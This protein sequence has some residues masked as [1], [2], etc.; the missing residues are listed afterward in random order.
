M[1]RYTVEV[2]ALYI[3]EADTPE[4]AK[5]M[6]ADGAEYPVIPYSEET[7]NISAEITEVKLEEN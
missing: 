1:A 3:V 2:S 4:Q 6:I 7:Y 5:E